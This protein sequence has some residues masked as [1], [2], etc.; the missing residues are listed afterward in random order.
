MYERALAIELEHRRI[1]FARQVTER[2]D[3]R[4]INI[5]EIRLDFL[6]ADRVI[7]ELKS[8]ESL[9]ATHVVQ[10]L[11]YLAI[12]CL[13]LALLINFNVP[14]LSQGLRRVVPRFP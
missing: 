10:C 11:S 2:L 6:I 9:S 7:V 14:V 4:G 12:T 5:G 8:V 1:P 3:Y 13:E